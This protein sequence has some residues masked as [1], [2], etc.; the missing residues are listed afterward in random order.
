MRPAAQKPHLRIQ[1]VVFIEGPVM[2]HL[3]IQLAHGVR[4]A[5]CSLVYSLVFACEQCSAS[6]GGGYR[7][8]RVFCFIPS[9]GIEVDESLCNGKLKPGAFDICNRESCKQFNE[10]MFLFPFHTALLL[11][12]HYA[13][14]LLGCTED[15]V[16]NFCRLIAGTAKCQ[17]RVI[18]EVLCC[19]TCWT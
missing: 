17:N 13:F 18:K 3:F 4:Y 1:N 15:E 12:V 10:D 7:V 9:T 2:T 5:H 19:R 14:T 8:R 11:P 16:P 6:C